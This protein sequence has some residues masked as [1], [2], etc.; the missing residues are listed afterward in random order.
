M[1]PLGLQHYC[2]SRGLFYSPWVEVLIGWVKTTDQPGSQ[3]R[4]RG[5]H[6]AGT[7]PGSSAVGS[8]PRMRGT[9]D[10]RIHHHIPARLIPAY[11]GN[12]TSEAVSSRVFPGSSPRMRGT[13][14]NVTQS[15]Y[16]DRLIPAYA[17]NT[18]AD[19][20]FYPLYQQNRI[21]LEPEPTHRIHHKNHS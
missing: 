14:P 5:E 3:P 8:S 13:H 9:L 16:V 7:L 4:S 21:S 20:G 6:S 2:G 1:R 11:A 19:L 17:G 10:A 15:G 12:T 18:L